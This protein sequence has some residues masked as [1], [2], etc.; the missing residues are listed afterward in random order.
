MPP[1]ISFTSALRNW[2]VFAKKN[3]N[4][5]KLVQILKNYFVK[6]W[7]EF[8]MILFCEWFYQSDFEALLL[9]VTPPPPPEVV[10]HN[11]FGLPPFIYFS[12]FLSHEKQISL[13]PHMLLSHRLLITIL[14][15]AWVVM[16]LLFREEPSKI[17]AKWRCT[18]A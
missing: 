1:N 9:C 17:N 5:T 7:Y 16:L 10:E 11:I 13:P 14:S 3:S 18:E 15:W 6:L 2:S 12:A 8:N 4:E